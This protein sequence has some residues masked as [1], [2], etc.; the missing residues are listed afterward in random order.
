M[1]IKLVVFDLGKVL[2]DFDLKKFTA[3]FA[4]K[5]SVARQDLYNLLFNYWALAAAFESGKLASPDFYTALADSTKYCGTYAEFCA[6]WN[7]IFT[8]MPDTRQLTTEK[9]RSQRYGNYYGRKIHVVYG[10]QMR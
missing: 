9:E 4:K 7:D 6:I 1:A 5:T 8:P 10:F 2:F 3:A